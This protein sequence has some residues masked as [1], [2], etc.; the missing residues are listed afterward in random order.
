MRLQKITNI[1]QQN[2]GDVIVLRN[3]ININQDG[4][5]KMVA[6]SPYAKIWADIE[7]K[8]SLVICNGKEQEELERLHVEPLKVGETLFDKTIRI[9]QRAGELAKGIKPKIINCVEDLRGID[10]FKALDA[11]THVLEKVRAAAR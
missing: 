5:D 2:F 8:D 6:D 7:G 9:S 3:G 1:R 10:G 4:L 11:V